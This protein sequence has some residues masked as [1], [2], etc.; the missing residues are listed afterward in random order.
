MKIEA[1]VGLFVAIG[2]VFLFLLTTQVNKFSNLGKKGY[3]IYALL[4]DASGLEK[5]AKVKIKGVDVGFVKDLG[6]EGAKVKALLFIFEGVK[7]PQDSIIVLQQQSLL[8]TKYLAI[9]PGSS[10]EYVQKGQ[11]L[12]RQKEFVSFDQTSTTINDAAKEFKSFIAELRKSIAGASGEDLKKSIENLQEITQNLK[13]LI[14]KNHDNISASIENIK[15]MGEELAAA[16]KKFG[17]MS[18]KFAYT[19]DSI[20]KDLPK[21]L[22]RVDE[23][24]LYLRDSGKDLKDKLPILMDRFAT[25]EED[26]QD[27]LK[28]NKQPLS[29]A[30]KSADNFFSSGSSSFKKLDNYLAAIGKSQIDVNFNSFYMIDDNYNK[31]SFS[32]SYIPTPNKYYILGIV[33]MDDYSQKDK[34]GNFIPPKKH[35]DAAYYVNAEYARRYANLRFRLG[36]IENTGGVGLDYYLFNDKGEASVDLYDF[37]AVNDVRGDE[38]HLTLRYR[39]RFLKHLDAYIGADN[40][41]NDKCRNF[42]VGMGLDFVDED[43]KYLLGTVSGAGSFIK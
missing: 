7:I 6:L 10:T 33:S 15:K 8:G 5:N 39:H 12:Q 37:N 19:A 20:N 38:P 1:K 9:E 32:V 40:I 4:D 17:N 31:N 43:M 26:L 27:I 24:T 30:I 22:Q 13:E 23:I 35:E 3:E 28:N 11:T 34:N 36:L 41:L 2:L 16:G 14:K 18:D 29:R 25:I 42:F 21:I